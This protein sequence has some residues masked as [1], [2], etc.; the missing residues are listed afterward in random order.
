MDIIYIGIIV[1]TIIIV[2]VSYSIVL[3]IMRNNRGE[4]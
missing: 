2:L 1:L 3:D 4:E